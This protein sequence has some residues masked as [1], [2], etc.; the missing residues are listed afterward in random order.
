M[1]GL[2]QQFI[3]LGTER[4][5]LGQPKRRS[6]RTADRRWNAASLRSIST[7]KACI[8]TWLEWADWLR[9]MHPTVRAVREI[10]PQMALEWLRELQARGRSDSTVRQYRSRLRKA[11]LRAEAR[12]WGPRTGIAG[13]LGELSLQPRRLDNRRRGGAYSNPE[14]KR[15]LERVAG[16]DPAVGVAL[17]AK[18][19]CGLRATELFCLKRAQVMEGLQVGQFHLEP[20][21]TKGG[22][23][24]Q[25]RVNDAGRTAFR[26]ALV[27]SGWAERPFALAE[28]PGASTRRAWRVVRRACRE[29][30]I[31]MRGLHG[32]RA[33][34]ARR[35]M[36]AARMRGLDPQAAAM[37]VS[38]R[39]GHGRPEVTAAYLAPGPGEGGYPEARVEA[40]PERWRGHEADL[41]RV[42][43]AGRALGAVTGLS[44]PDLVEISAASLRCALRTGCLASRQGMIPLPIPLQESLRAVCALTPGSRFPLRAYLAPDAAV[45]LIRGQDILSGP[46]IIPGRKPPGTQDGERGGMSC[47]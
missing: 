26:E 9:E 22:R 45:C 5:E 39:L 23:P 28:T 14:A 31:R 35:W 46:A 42:L 47:R 4:T 44:P 32:L 37:D 3:R 29:L 40:V 41:E 16:L 19:A 17:R 13:R 27:S 20:S 25:V 12:G 15:L 36:A 38:R 30:G 11:A 2:R 33:T 34:A 7:R 21:Q 43:A 10:E 18:L 8:R 24:R 6:G 1:A